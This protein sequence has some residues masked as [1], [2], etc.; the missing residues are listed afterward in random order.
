MLKD[1]SAVKQF[2]RGGERTMRSATG[3]NPMKFMPDT[4]A[5]LEVMFLKQRDGFMHGP[6]GFENALRDIRRHQTAVF[7]ALQPALAELLSNLSPDEI[8]AAV[9]GGFLGTGSRAKYW[10]AFVARW[11]EKASVGDNGMLDAFLQAFAE[12][13]AA[14]AGKAGT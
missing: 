10:D 4:G 9:G 1:R 3:N 8:E 6:D 7:A 14:A 12:S 11:D 5:A 2:T 13:Y